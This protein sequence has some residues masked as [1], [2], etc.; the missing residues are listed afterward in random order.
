MGLVV[1]N[2]TMLF[3]QR[4]AQGDFQQHSEEFSR[5]FAIGFDL[6]SNVSSNLRRRHSARSLRRVIG[7]IK[8]ELGKRHKCY[9]RLSEHRERH[10]PLLP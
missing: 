5:C 9:G 6:L 7:V 8:V 10:C 4:F 1:A 3:Y 2:V